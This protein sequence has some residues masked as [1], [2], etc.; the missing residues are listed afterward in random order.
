MHGEGSENYNRIVPIGNARSLEIGANPY[1]CTA[2]LTNTAR[3]ELDSEVNTLS[4]ETYDVSA[5][6]YGRVNSSYQ[7]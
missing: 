3:I 5:P 6:N 1:S 4:M 2:L 7:A